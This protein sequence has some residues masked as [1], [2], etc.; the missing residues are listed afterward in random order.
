M[1]YNAKSIIDT[2]SFVAYPMQPWP[3]MLRRMFLTEMT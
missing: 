2:N 1:Y 3:D